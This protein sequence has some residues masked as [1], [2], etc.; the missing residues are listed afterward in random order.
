[1]AQCHRIIEGNLSLNNFETLPSDPNI[2][3]APS[4]VSDTKFSVRNYSAI[5]RVSRCEI[6]AVNIQLAVTSSNSIKSI[7]NFMGS[8]RLNS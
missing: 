4:Q 2:T 5:L 6:R 3:A 1:L 8:V 7:N